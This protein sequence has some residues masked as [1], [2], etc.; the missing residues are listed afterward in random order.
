M[1]RDLVDI[2]RITIAAREQPVLAVSERKATREEVIQTKRRENANPYST[3]YLNASP[4]LISTNCIPSH[5]LFSLTLPPLALH[6]TSPP[7]LISLSTA[8]LGVSTAGLTSR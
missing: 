2:N 4:A 6:Q 1:R 5:Y 7:H 3:A 8:A